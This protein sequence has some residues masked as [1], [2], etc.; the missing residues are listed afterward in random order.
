[1]MNAPLKIAGDT[2]SHAGSPP[3]L[4]A[5]QALLER[6]E[7]IVPAAPVTVVPGGTGVG[8]TTVARA[9]CEHHGGIFID[10]GAR[11]QA[12]RDHSTNAARDAL[13]LMVHE[14][15]AKNDMVV[16]DDVHKLMVRSCR[17][18]DEFFTFSALMAP[19][20]DHGKRL[21]C[22]GNPY[23]I[24]H[25][26]APSPNR[27][28]R[29]EIDPFGPEDYRQLMLMKLGERAIAE[30][31][32]A[33]VHQRASALNGHDLQKLANA[34]RSH[35]PL[36]TADVLAAMDRHVV[37]SNTRLAEVE[38][39]D[40]AELP[41]TDHICEKL[42]THIILPFEHPRVARELNLSPKRGVLLYGPPG[43]GKTS[44]G[45]ALAH[46]MKGK[47]FL[48]DGSVITE[49]PA[50]FFGKVKNIVAAAQQSA[51]AVLFIDDA[52]VLF[53][54]T[55]IQGFARYLL[56]LLDGM[57][58]EGIGKVCLMMTAMNPSRIPSAILRSGRVELWLE[59][60][61]PDLETRAAI[62]RR[63]LGSSLPGHDAVEWATLLA[64]AEGFTPADLRRVVGDA[65][66]YY[67]A[68]QLAGR[69]GGTAQAYLA[70]AIA[71]LIATRARM[72]DNLRDESLRVGRGATSAKYGAGIGG[73][74]E[75]CSSCAVKGW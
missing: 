15:L 40:F 73:L 38:A 26:M 7:H 8:K 62:L 27:A 54:I 68:D 4:P 16:V 67:T 58:S 12:M 45:R 1:M 13:I 24:D 20:H 18:H 36:A 35:G 31:D 74:V 69:S 11:L 28:R 72:A 41:G 61:A 5:Q 65:R 9:F 34:L 21:V 52:D 59:T 10:T 30:V 48:I 50:E 6:L 2:S 33:T 23:W 19:A 47:F 3:L 51:P 60:R 25:F 66:A 44:I 55:H 29:V 42:E 63:W 32:F 17:Q 37:T 53:G 49:P 22:T 57:E 14:A 39:L 75:A 43:T 71:E 64:P 46:R 56:T 70:R